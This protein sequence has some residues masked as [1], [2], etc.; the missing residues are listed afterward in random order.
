MKT[1][2]HTKQIKSAQKIKEAVKTGTFI[3]VP[4]VLIIFVVINF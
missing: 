2:K 3:I 4:L 1:K